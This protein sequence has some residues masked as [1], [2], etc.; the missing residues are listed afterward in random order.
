LGLSLWV[1]RPGSQK[2]YQ[3][4][5]PKLQVLDYFWIEEFWKLFCVAQ[6]KRGSEE[7][8][9]LMREARDSV[10]ISQSEI[11]QGRKT[12]LSADAA[13][14]RI[15]E[16]LRKISVDK[17]VD[18]IT[19]WTL[20]KYE[21]GT[22]LPTLEVLKAAEAAYG[23]EDKRLSE[24]ILNG[25]N[26]GLPG[27][28]DGSSAFISMVRDRRLTSVKVLEGGGCGVWSRRVAGMTHLDL[29]SFLEGD[30]VVRLKTSAFGFPAK[31]LLAFDKSK[32][33]YPEIGCLLLIENKADPDKLTIR[34]IDPYGDPTHYTGCE[35]VEPLPISEWNVLGWCL[36]Y[37]TPVGFGYPKF[38]FDTLG[39][40]PLSLR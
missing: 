38:I 31:S 16:E 18:K 14:E 26:S 30:E 12:T 24:Y 36:A 20:Y 25:A 11:R 28:A 6:E 23:I 19:R 32:D 17:P 22:Q 37:A 15:N 40:K 5:I 2:A 39:V 29:F 21:D 1:F 7:L 4:Y 3:Q 13:A 34:R 27:N 10:V 33:G 8:G 35:G 9:R